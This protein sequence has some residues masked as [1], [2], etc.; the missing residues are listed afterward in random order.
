MRQRSYSYSRCVRNPA[1]F[2]PWRWWG[3]ILQVFCCWL[4][5]LAQVFRFFP[6]RVFVLTQCLVFLSTSFLLPRASLSLC[7]STFCSSA[8]FFFSFVF[9]FCLFL[10]S[11]LARWHVR[12]PLAYSSRLALHGHRTLRYL[13]MCICVVVCDHSGRLSRRRHRLGHCVTRLT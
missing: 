6:F 10:A 3:G 8:F 9:P 5:R 12:V 13:A 1:G 2:C 4:L 7:L 11:C